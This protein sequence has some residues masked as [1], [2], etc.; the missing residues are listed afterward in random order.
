MLKTLA[1]AIPVIFLLLSC[2]GQ[3]SERLSREGI[4][5]PLIDENRKIARKEDHLI[6]RFVARRKWDMEVSGTGLRYM[7]YDKGEG[8]KAEEGMKATVDYKISLTNGRVCY[9]S[10]EKGPRTFTIGHDNVESGIHEGI[11]YMQVGDHAKLVIP[12]YLAHGLLGD[13]KEIP[14]RAT[15]V[16]DLHLLRLD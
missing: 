13:Q 16:V 1:V 12:S 4:K 3:R 14:P 2:N 11:T 5:E 6:D 7:I 9:S 10:E 15:L 8:T